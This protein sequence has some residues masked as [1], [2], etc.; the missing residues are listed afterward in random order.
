MREKN[1]R[2]AVGRVTVAMSN[3][4]IAMETEGLTHATVSNSQHL[5][6]IIQTKC[7][8]L[9]ARPSHMAANKNEPSDFFSNIKSVTAYTQSKTDTDCL[10]VLSQGQFVSVNH[11]F[12]EVCW[13]HV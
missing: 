8:T 6:H 3:S 9:C 1:E 13:S 2:K 5:E 11:S 7:R 12:P 10:H 4:T